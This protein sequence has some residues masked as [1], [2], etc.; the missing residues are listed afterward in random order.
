MERLRDAHFRIRS[1]HLAQGLADFADG[2]IG[3]DGVNYEGHGIDVGNVA[4]NASGGSLGCGPFQ[5]FEPALDF[6]I[7]AAG[8][9]FSLGLTALT[10]RRM[11][12]VFC[13]GSQNVDEVGAKKPPEA[14]K[15]FWACDK[16]AVAHGA[17]SAKVQGADGPLHLYLSKSSL[18]PNNRFS[19]N[20]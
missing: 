10:T 15:A 7:R 17:I 19:A 9:L 20:C 4:V 1:V 5:C 16:A 14:T 6:F 3:A 11:N 13:G 8:A 12:L 18:A 2:R